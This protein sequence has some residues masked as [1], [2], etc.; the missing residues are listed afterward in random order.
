MWKKLLKLL[1]TTHRSSEELIPPKQCEEEMTR[2]CEALLRPLFALS[3]SFSLSVLLKPSSPPLFVLQQD[4]TNYRPDPFLPTTVNSVGRI[5]MPFCQ[6]LPLPPT[7]AHFLFVDWYHFFYL[8]SFSFHYSLRGVCVCMSWL[9]HCLIYSS[10]V[11][12]FVCERAFF[13]N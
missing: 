1:E 2:S 13:E 10:F 7:V 4:I 11:Y 8:I 12:P 5:H 3:V 6:K 9:T